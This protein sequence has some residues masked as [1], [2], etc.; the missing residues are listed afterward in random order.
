VPATSASIGNSHA[1]IHVPGHSCIVARPCGR[2]VRRQRAAGKALDAKQRD[3]V[4]C[5]VIWACRRTSR[6]QQ[7][8]WVGL[9]VDIC[10]ALRLPCSVTRKVKW[11]PLKRAAHHSADRA[12]S[13]SC[14]ATTFTLTRDASLGLFITAVTYYD[15]QGFIVPKNPNH[16]RQAAQERRSACSPAPR[17]RRT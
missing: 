16:Q 14:P 7:G 9:D 5:S 1:Q 3:Q 8:N 11:V 12:K 10:K 13:T 17:P 6:R 4:I 2:H 15:G